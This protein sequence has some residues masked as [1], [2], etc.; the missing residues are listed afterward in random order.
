MLVIIGPTGVGKSALSNLIGVK[1]N[2]EIVNAD[3][4]QV[5]RGM[6]I[7]TAKPSQA[8]INSFPHH[9]FDIVD[10]DERFDV[11]MFNIKAKLVI[12]QINSRKSIPIVV[13]GTGQYIWSIVESWDINKSGS[14][15]EVRSR[16]EREYM[17]EGL[18][19]LV[20]ELLRKDPKNSVHVDL[21]N[22][23]RVIRALERVELGFDA[24]S[25][26]SKVIDLS[27]GT[28]IAGLSL[29][30]EELY[31]RVDQRINSMIHSGWLREVL[32]LRSSGY[33]K[34]LRSMGSIGYRE[35]HGFLEKE[36]SWQ[37]CVKNIRSRTHRLIRTQENW[38]KKDDPRIHWFD[39]S[40]MNFEEIAASVYNQYKLT[41]IK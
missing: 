15:P 40:K 4:S 27:P 26:R 17:A 3:S 9:L 37:E 5:Y 7:G 16:I 1:F 11:H 18:E 6:D 25:P 39:L 20:S 38:F 8:E 35:L 31:K 34:T 30:R 29:G 24:T 36:F 10:P 22:P 12:D 2:G 41:P 33:K 28:F 23:R 14:D 19:P 21:K 13:G 32:M